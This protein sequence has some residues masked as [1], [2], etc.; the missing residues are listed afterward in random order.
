ME[1]RGKGVYVEKYQ[2]RRDDTDPGLADWRTKFCV[3]LLESKKMI[4]AVDRSPFS[5]ATIGRRLNTN[6]AEFDQRLH[7]MVTET[8]ARLAWEV[9]GNINEDMD[10]LPPG[11][12]RAL[13]GLKYLERRSPKRWNPVL[14]MKHSGNVV[15]SHVA[16]GP[17]GGGTRLAELAESQA[18]FFKNHDPKALPEGDIIEAEVVEVE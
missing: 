13:I 9:E 2:P 10:A 4:V 1:A 11:R 12:D 14:E 18:T 17:G 7:D 6:H 15:H 5:Y 8:E 3:D 16:V